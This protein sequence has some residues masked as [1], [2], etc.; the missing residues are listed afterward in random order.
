M[1]R[2][3]DDRQVA[4]RLG[5]AA[6]CTLGFCDQWVGWLSWRAVACVPCSDLNGVIMPEAHHVTTDDGVQVRYSSCPQG[7][8]AEVLFPAAWQ[9]VILISTDQEAAELQVA[10]RLLAERQ[11]RSRGA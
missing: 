2:C 10:E 6:T 5:R 3:G 8:L 9:A 1:T 4:A 7:V 11:H